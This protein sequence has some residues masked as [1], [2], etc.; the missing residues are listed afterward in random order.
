MWNALKSNDALKQSEIAETCSLNG[1]PLSIIERVF[2]LGG[3]SGEMVDP[4]E[5]IILLITM[6]V[7]VRE[8]MIN[9]Q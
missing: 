3:F 1:I 2:H 9:L 4:K 6:S 7:K 5:V 8:I